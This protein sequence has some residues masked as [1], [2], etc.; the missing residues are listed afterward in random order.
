MPTSK[1][2]LM[3]KEEERC[4]TWK[5]KAEL[6][7]NGLV[8]EPAAGVAAQ[9]DQRPLQPSSVRS[10]SSATTTEP[11]QATSGRGPDFERAERCKATKVPVEVPHRR[12]VPD[13][14]GRNKT[15]NRGTDR[16]SS[17]PGCSVQIRGL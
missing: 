5:K 15:V 8:I 7:G 11:D 17:P 16:D 3:T 6:L 2:A 14:D 1:S 10:D 12:L 4:L 13:R 9:D